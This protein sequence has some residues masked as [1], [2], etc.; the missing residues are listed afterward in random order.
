[1]LY[2]LNVYKPTFRWTMA[3]DWR[4]FSSNEYFPIEVFKENLK[5][6]LKLSLDIDDIIAK[7]TSNNKTDNNSNVNYKINNH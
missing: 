7:N 3:H 6:L 4:S 1:M 2:T 5:L